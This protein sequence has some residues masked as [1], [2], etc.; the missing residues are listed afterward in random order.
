MG[1][2]LPTGKLRLTEV[3]G[4]LAGEV[5]SSPGPCEPESCA[6]LTATT[7]T[8]E[9]IEPKDGYVTLGETLAS[10]GL[11]SSEGT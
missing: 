11:S 6:Y 7:T 2:I 5:R 8:L 3:T 4:L 9:C 10:L 1:L